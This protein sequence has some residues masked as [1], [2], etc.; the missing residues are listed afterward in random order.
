MLKQVDNNIITYQ[1]HFIFYGIRFEFYFDEKSNEMIIEMAE[2]QSNT[3]YIPD[4]I[5]GI[6]VSSIEFVDWRISGFDKVIISD[7]N[8]NFKVKDGVLF[9]SDM[10]ELLIYPPEK[11]DEIYYI[12]TGVEIIGEDS[13]SSNKYIKTIIFP[14]GFRTVV[15]YALACCHSLETIYFPRTLENILLKAFY[16]AESV[17]NVYFEGTEKEWKTILVSDCNWSLTN[18]EIHF[19]YDYHEVTSCL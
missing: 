19:N 12:P 11:K 18:A 6:P 4:K 5:N 1:N 2:G 7:D 9:T 15:Q 16:F 3:L 10:K 8:S 17:R 13:F 14:N